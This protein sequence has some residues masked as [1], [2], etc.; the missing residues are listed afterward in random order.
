MMA[1]DA[2]SGKKL[3][4]GVQLSELGYK[5]IELKKYSTFDE[6]TKNSNTWKY[7]GG[8]FTIYKFLFSRA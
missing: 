6:C 4:F 2:I 3:G 8:V 1:V 5:C 7:G